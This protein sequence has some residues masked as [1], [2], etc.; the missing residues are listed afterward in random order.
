M[1]ALAAEGGVGEIAETR[2][3]ASVSGQFRAYCD[4][5]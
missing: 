4:A 5:N 3:N 2:S 1:T